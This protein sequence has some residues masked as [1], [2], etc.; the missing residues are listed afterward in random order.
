MKENG[1]GVYNKPLILLSP[2]ER[3]NSNVINKYIWE[4]P[5]YYLQAS[6]EVQ[7]TYKVV[8]TVVLSSIRNIEIFEG[9]ITGFLN[10]VMNLSGYTISFE[11]KE[12]TAKYSIDP[13]KTKKKILNSWFRNAA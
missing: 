9:N 8:D 12:G 10:R 3:C 6:H 5:K 1:V 11:I 2:E 7:K 4:N 13:P